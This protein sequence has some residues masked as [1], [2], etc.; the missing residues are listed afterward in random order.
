MN[1]ET[2]LVSILVAVYNVEEHL[3]KSLNSIIHQTFKNLEIIIVND[4]STDSSL[5]ICENYRLID[6][7]IKLISK[8]NEGL[9]S[10]RNLGLELAKGD[11][12]Y[13]TDSDD[14]LLP[15]MIEKMVSLIIKSKA[16]IAICDYFLNQESTQVN[17]S[18]ITVKRINDVMP[19]LLI[20]KISSQVWN[21]LFCKDVINST[22]FPE[23]MIAQD[24]GVMHLFFQNAKTCVLTNEKLYVYYSIRSSNTSSKNRS[25][26]QGSYH[27]A[28]H[29]YNRYNFSQLYYPELSQI[30]LSKSVHFYVS[31]YLKSLIENNTIIAK[32]IFNYLALLKDEIFPNKSINIWDKFVVH[33]ILNN[34]TIALAFLSKIGKLVLF[35]K[36]K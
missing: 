30:I 6:S 28:I 24:L 8:E 12:I 36:Y 13:M 35:F 3:N 2:P 15:D 5:S 10:A 16:D 9:S 19:D 22:R 21:K 25:T 7:R 20:D 27:R 17:E 31:A 1:F 18:K 32:S 34:K 23:K 26:V 29:F 11:F 33:L 4:G 14:Y